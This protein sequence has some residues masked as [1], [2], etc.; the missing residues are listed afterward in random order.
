MKTFSLEK[1][2]SDSKESRNFPASPTKGF[3]LTSSQCPGASPIN[4]ISAFGLPSPGTAF[5]RVFQ[6]GHL[7]QT[8]TSAAITSRDSFLD[9]AANPHDLIPQFI[10]ISINGNQ[11]SP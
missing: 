1:R 2:I 7:M 5:L 6:S 3:P 11:M 4:M 10:F 8:V 9:K